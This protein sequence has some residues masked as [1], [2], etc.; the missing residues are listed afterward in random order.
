[1]LDYVRAT[2]DVAA[3]RELWPVAH[4]Q[5]KILLEYVDANGLFQTP[6]GYWAFIDWNMKLDRT[7][8]MQGLMIYAGRQLVELA[9]MTGNAADVV[10]YP[11]LLDKM[12]AAGYVAYYDKAQK[13]CVSGPERQVSWAS[14]A[15]MTL[16]GLLPKDEAAG[17]L[18]RGVIEDTT[19]VQPST[20]Y[21]YHHVAEAMVQCGMRAEAM[22]LIEQYWGGMVEDGA[23]TFWEAFDPKDST[24]SPYG[25]VHIN[26]FCHAWSC[27]PTWFFRS[28]GLGSLI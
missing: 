21:L 20:A 27:T 1:V 28:P 12:S 10:E 24:F 16:G 14:Q 7:A 19:S 18:R 17:A 26:S 2:K 11:A 9:R 6:K 13:V 3:A 4:R 22:T 5:M 23:D 8:A 15:W 25:D